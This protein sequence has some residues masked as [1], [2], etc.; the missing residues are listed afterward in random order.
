MA[1][2]WVIEATVPGSWLRVESFMT[3]LVGR[4][5]VTADVTH[6]PSFV[7]RFRRRRRDLDALRAAWHG[8][9]TNP[10]Q[11]ARVAAVGCDSIARP[12]PLL[13]TLGWSL[14]RT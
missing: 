1:S 8:L 5:T 2:P 3:L 11:V 10:R 12:H 6:E 7:G 14:C 9:A 13:P 4:W